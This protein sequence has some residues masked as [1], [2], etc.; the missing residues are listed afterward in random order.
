M[1]DSVWMELVAEASLLVIAGLALFPAIFG[2]FFISRSESRAL[3]AATCAWALFVASLAV[4]NVVITVGNPSVEASMTLVTIRHILFCLALFAGMWLL[5]SISGN[6]APVLT[7][8]LGGLLLVRAVLWLTTDLVWQHAISAEGFAVEGPLRGVGTVLVD[9]VSV[10]ILVRV[11]LPPW[12]SATVKKVCLWALVPTLLLGASIFITPRRVQDYIMVVIVALP[13]VVVL[14]ALF[15]GLADQ[16]RQVKIRSG[17]DA[18]VADFGRRALTPGGVVPAQA[19]VDL[20]ADELPDV[21]SRYLERVAGQLRPV[22]VAGVDPTNKEPTIFSVPIESGGQTVGELSVFGKLDSQD[23]VFVRG[24]SLVLSAALSRAQME[25]RL[26]D[27]SLL[28]AV[29]GLP[30]WA[31]LQDRLSR[32]LS[33]N[34]GRM[35][36]VM[37]C[38]ITGLKEVNDEFGHD[39]GDALLREV[40]FR[41]ESLTSDHSTVARI[42]ADEFIVAQYVDDVAAA[43][44]LSRQAIT[45]GQEPMIAGESSVPFDVRAGLVVAHDAITDSD[46]LVRD[47]EIAL[48]Q[49]KRSATQRAAYSETVREAES[50]R[51]KLARALAVGVDRGE[52]FVEYQPIIELKTRKVVGVEALARWCTPEGDIVPPLEFIPLAEANGLIKPMTQTVF[53]QALA[54]VSRWDNLDEGDGDQGIA[55]LRLSLNVTPNAVGD[56]DF[57][58]WLTGLLARHQID[59]SRITLELTESSLERAQDGVLLNLHSIRS[60]GVRL[61]L[62]DFGTGYSTFDRLLNLPV[63]E[64]KID[65]RFTKTG[66]GPHRKIV[67]SVVALAHSSNLAVVAEGIET[68]EQ[69]YMLMTDGCEYG[70]GFLFSRPLPGPGIPK[71]IRAANR[72][73]PL[74]GGISRSGLKPRSR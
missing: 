9:L 5:Q 71:Y 19:A 40:G 8:I 42:G 20:I 27:Q 72:A 26:R 14:A 58:G 66:A 15:S 67:P 50:A 21:R 52:I 29:T 33:N 25:E 12:K 6:R 10:A 1:G 45:I 18:R 30:N 22:A 31:L 62:D 36:A 24:V 47:A 60:L 16:Y 7:A 57:V 63:S 55:G 37:C 59:P 35:V 54:E 53:D 61:S 48:M 34:G 70:Q 64:L 49:A 68:R 65:R 39:V 13:M 44:R 73:D 23:A 17:R 69:W 32:M 51:R 56:D 11:M 46:R 43:D 38:D 2:A 41:L 74:R 28:D 3:W 4:V